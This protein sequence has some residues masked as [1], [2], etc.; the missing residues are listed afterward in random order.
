MRKGT[1][2]F[3]TLVICCVSTSVSLQESQGGRREIG[4]ARQPKTNSRHPAKTQEHSGQRPLRMVNPAPIIKEPP[5]STD[6]VIIIQIWPE[7][8][9]QTVCTVIRPAKEE[10]R[11]IREV[12]LE[13]YHQVLECAGYDFSDDI[14]LPYNDEYTDMYFE[15]F[16]SELYMKVREDDTDIQDMGRTHSLSEII[17]V[18]DSGWSAI[19]AVHLNT[20]H[21]YV[22][23]TWDDEYVKFRVS[24][25]SPN[26][27]EFDWISLLRE[28]IP[29]SRDKVR[30]GAP[31]QLSSQSKFGR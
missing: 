7:P 14:V 6:P 30:E 9:P 10:L 16:N 2:V 15:N 19:H 29:R 4:V 20:G 3:L 5:P 31:K 8:I 21:T 26:E 25:L 13:D 1:A 17:N 24:R 28:P 12:V 23:W 22:V 27:V 18:P 11:R